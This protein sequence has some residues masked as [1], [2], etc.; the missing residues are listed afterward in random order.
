MLIKFKVLLAA[1]A[2]GWL[3]TPLA[4]AQDAT[5]GS[6][7]FVPKQE[8]RLSYASHLNALGAPNVFIR[9]QC[10]KTGGDCWFEIKNNQGKLLKKFGTQTRVKQ[11]AK[12]R[13]SKQAYLYFYESY[14]SGDKTIYNYY[15]INNQG[16]I[17]RV[18][19]YAN[20]ALSLAINK[21]GK[22][23]AI[24]AW[25][26]YENNEEV[27]HGTGQALEFARF[28]TSPEGR[29]AAIG[30]NGQGEIYVSNL[31]RWQ[32]T[33]VKLTNKSDRLG[34]LS[35]YPGTNKVHFAV[36][37]YINSYNKGLVYGR[38]SI[39]TGKTASGWLFNSE[40]ENI[41]FD[42]NIYQQNNELV[43][44][45]TNSTKNEYAH[46]LLPIN[47][48]EPALIAGKPEH[49]KGFEEEKNLE[50]LIGT[51]LASMNWKAKVDV[52]KDSTTYG[53]T[54]YDLSKSLYK[55]LWFQGKWGSKQ[56]A[57][58]YAKNEADKK[59]GKTRKAST[60]L[61]AIVDFNQLFSARSSLRLTMD[62]SRLNGLARMDV[63]DSSVTNLTSVDEVEFETNFKQYSAL[64]LRERGLYW[65]LMYEDYKM[66]GLLGF[67]NSSKRISHLGYDAKTGLTKYGLVVGYDEMD[68][69]KRYENNISRFYFDGLIGAAFV[70]VDV[71]GD[72]KNAIKNDGKKLKSASAFSLDAKLDL[73]YVHQRKIKRWQGVGYLLNAGY[74][75]K[76]SYMGSGQSSSSDRTIEANELEL[77]FGRFDLWHGLYANASLVF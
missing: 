53:K 54:H 6:Y 63:L 8:G 56:L 37:S 42:P 55:S 31:K 58:S 77:E 18:G 10:P 71:S 33:Q 26:I 76:A 27:L 29:L 11:L 9:T 17:Q 20:G 73:G 25:G 32:N 44:S 5:T 36:Y 4:S 2:I 67:S 64:V 40:E 46:F 30:I 62:Q 34:V 74:R 66:P 48:D 39:E 1:L 75:V 41:G 28:G 51:G 45:A 68:Y 50:L 19:N 16:K 60:L 22:V 72:L 21:T 59:G 38:T 61:N 7:A 70:K 3:I 47:L 69:I 12:T 65:G 43:V 52:E 23:L 14:P 35:V 57:L 24:K 15:V 13:Y 49:I